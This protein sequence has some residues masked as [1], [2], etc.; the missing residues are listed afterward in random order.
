VTHTAGCAQRVVTVMTDGD[1]NNGDAEP[2]GLVVILLGNSG[3]DTDPCHPCLCNRRWCCP[4]AQM[5]HMRGSRTLCVACA[6]S[7]QLG[8]HLS[9]HFLAPCKN[10]H[11]VGRSEGTVGPS[12]CGALVIHLNV[13]E[14]VGRDKIWSNYCCGVSCLSAP[15]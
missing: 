6:S 14:R 3:W 5:I 8:S 11:G 1:H 4:D 13:Q 15:Y 10:C 12:G 7:F 2:I 9:C